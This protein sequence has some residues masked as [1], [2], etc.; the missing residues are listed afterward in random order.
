MGHGQQSSRLSI[1]TPH[2]SVN[3]NSGTTTTRRGLAT[4]YTP[5][6]YTLR[7]SPPRRESRMT[8]RYTV[9][10]MQPPLTFRPHLRTPHSRLYFSSCLGRPLSSWQPLVHLPGDFRLSRGQKLARRDKRPVFACSRLPM[11][12]LRANGTTKT[13]PNQTRTTPEPMTVHRPYKEL[14]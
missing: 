11:L 4:I 1:V 13:K 2:R 6:Q 14:L 7:N 3:D 5:D 8:H 12:V 10:E 9:P